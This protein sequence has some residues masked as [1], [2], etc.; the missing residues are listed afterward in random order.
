MNPFY[1]QVYA[2][3]AQIP[4]GRV[5]SY[6]QIARILGKPRAAREVGRAMRIC[7]PGLPWQRVVMADGQVTGGAYAYMRKELLEAEG[8]HFLPDGRVDMDACRW[9]PDIVSFHL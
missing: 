3:T 4:C 5:M 9:G 7:P 1:A 6:G 2:I 8:V